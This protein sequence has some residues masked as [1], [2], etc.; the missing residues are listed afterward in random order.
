MLSSADDRSRPLDRDKLSMVPREAGI[1]AAY[2]ALF[3]IQD[4]A[5][6]PMMAGVAV[7]FAAIC[8]RTG[9]DPEDMHRLGMKLLR[10]QEGSLKTNN[11][12]QSLRDFA[13]LRIAGQDVVMS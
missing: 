1:E 2:E 10:Y 6:E 9:T 8:N 3:P 7:L 12:V 11:A 13:G 4:R 5:P